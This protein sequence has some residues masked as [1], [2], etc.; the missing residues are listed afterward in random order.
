MLVQSS[1]GAYR[2]MSAKD[3]GCKESVLLVLAS[4]DTFSG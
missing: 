4:E 1:Q 2:V 3:L